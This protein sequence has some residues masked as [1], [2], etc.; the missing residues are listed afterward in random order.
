MDFAQRELDIPVRNPDAAP[1][2]EE[3][4]PYS[5]LNQARMIDE[6]NAMKANARAEA[7]AQ[8]AEARAQDAEARAQDV[9]ARARDAEARARD[10]PAWKPNGYAWQ[11]EHRVHEREHS[12]DAP[13]VQRCPDGSFPLSSGGG[14]PGVC[15]WTGALMR[16]GTSAPGSVHGSL[17]FV[18]R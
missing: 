5:I 13:P 11:P 10:V 17:R 7:R 15:R 14:G 16:G 6:R 3:E 4:N 18:P 9:E 2:A 8:D 12:A 1:G